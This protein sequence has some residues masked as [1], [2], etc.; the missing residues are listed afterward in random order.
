MAENK[1]KNVAVLGAGVM[2]GGIAAHLAGCGV[3]VLLLDRGSLAIEAI[4]RL[5]KSKP[6]LTY[7]Q[8]DLSNIIAGS[9]ETDLERLKECDWIIEAVTEKI[10]IKQNLYK[11]IE[12][13]LNPNAVVSSNTSGLGWTLLTNGM[14]KNFQNSFLITHFFNPTRYMKL[15]E[16]VVGAGTEPAKLNVI[17][18]FCEER[19][20][21]GVV[22]AKDTPNFIANRIGVMHVMDIIHLANENGWSIETVDDVLGVPAGRPKSAIFRTVDLSGIDTLAYAAENIIRRCPGDEM[23]VRARI[24]NYIMQMIAKNWVGEKS[25]QGFYKKDPK[26]KEIF[27][28]NPATLEYRPAEKLKAPSL[29]AA[30]ELLNPSERLKTIVWADDEGGKIAWSAISRML[31]YSANRIPEISEDIISVDRAMRW[32]FKWSLGPFETWDALGV[33][34]VAERL[35]REGKEIPKIVQNLLSSDNNSFYRL[36]NSK[37]FFFDT[38]AKNFLPEGENNITFRNL[39]DEKIV[40]KNAGAS[41]VDLNDGVFACEF[42][43][44]M[45]AVDPDI[46]AMIHLGLDKTEKDGIGLLIANDGENFSVGANLMLVLMAAE[47]GR[48]AELEK[49][50]DDFQKTMQRIRFSPKPVISAPFGMTF[51]GGFEICLASSR[52]CAAA[53]TYTGFVEPGVGLIPAGCGCKNFLLHMENIAEGNGPFPKISKA[54]ETIAMARTSTSAKEA[55]ELGFLTKNDKIVLDRERL[56]LE[57]KNELIK[58]S[59]GYHPPVLRED[60]HL[61]G[62]GGEMALVSAIRGLREQGKA[63]QYDAVIAE[64][65][66]HV[67]TGGDKPTTHKTTEQHILDLEREAFLKLCGMEKTRERM[68]HMLMTGKPLKN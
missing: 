16:I 22:L 52:Q 14:S 62:K 11:K 30:K 55:L 17:R 12:P 5:K 4:L 48:W 44:K 31:I 53:E 33:R 34:D 23:T 64:H 50:V 9:F 67:L 39:H 15:V 59:T 1:I 47:G 68:K 10:D 51:G 13:F 21:K 18:K 45:N 36:K 38:K 58:L 49:M 56:T 61:P 37:K 3:N 54:F 7:S 41:L 57:A 28:I 26:T 66:A 8:N 60:I 24:P 65:L 6:S 43:T 27:A 19:L 42:R 32:G 20:G 63:T 35:E 29:S 40:S 2:G 46:A 25:G